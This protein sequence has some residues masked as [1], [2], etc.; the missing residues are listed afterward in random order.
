VFLVCAAAAAPAAATQL[1]PTSLEEMAAAADL[2]V[3]GR[4]V[5]GGKG[6]Y[7]SHWGMILTH[8]T[9]L[10]DEV[11]KGELVGR[12]V[13][14]VV[15]GGTD[16]EDWT[17][18]VGA[19][20]PGPPGTVV[21]AFLYAERGTKMSNVVFWQGL[22]HVEEGKVRENGRDA[23]AFLEEVRAAVRASGGVAR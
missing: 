6:R 20:E 7:D 1:L 16:G 8:R 14:L 5:G 10:V 13:P 17:E 9:I 3:V 12:A 15:P 23:A 4:L 19:P 22:F 2:V 21:V 18:V 11:L